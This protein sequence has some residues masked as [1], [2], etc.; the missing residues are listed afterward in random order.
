[1]L[2]KQEEGVADAS[3]ALQFVFH[4]M[5]CV[6]RL[7][8]RYARMV[9]SVTACLIGST[10]LHQQAELIDSVHAVDV[11]KMTHSMAVAT[12]IVI[13]HQHEWPPPWILGTI[14]VQKRRPFE[15]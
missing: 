4:G 7:T 8:C 2:A 14:E 12:G 11:G 10:S 15:L 1:M 9:A 6:R 13:A 5:R 3:G